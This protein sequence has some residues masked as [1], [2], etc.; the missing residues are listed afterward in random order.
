[1]RASLLKLDLAFL[2]P[3]IS[4]VATM[5]RISLSTDGSDASPVDLMTAIRR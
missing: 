3:F 4:F 1:M 2:W 5:V